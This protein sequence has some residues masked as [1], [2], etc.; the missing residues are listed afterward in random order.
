[1]KRMLTILMASA[2]IAIARPELQV[3][4]GDNGN[5]RIKYKGD[6]WERVF[7]YSPETL[8]MWERE[9]NEA[10]A[11]L[12]LVALSLAALVWIGFI[13]A[14]LCRRDWNEAL[15]IFRGPFIL[16]ACCL[17][18]G[19]AFVIVVGGF[20]SIMGGFCLL[21]GWL[22]RAYPVLGT[23]SWGWIIFSTIAGYF[24]ISW[25]IAHYQQIKEDQEELRQVSERWEERRLLATAVEQQKEV[26]E[27]PQEE[28]EAELD[29]LVKKYE[30]GAF[31]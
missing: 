7:E 6:T 24:A 15:S 1:M 9:R 3:Y 12:I 18:I 22:E 29:A 13:I 20:V 23:I 2:S 30:K 25:I 17:M 10:Q 5:E 21:M 27:I 14:A 4:E 11:Q 31:Q 19:I 26:E 16:A 28:Q 8:A